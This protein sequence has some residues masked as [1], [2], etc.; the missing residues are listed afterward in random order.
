MPDSSSPR[1]VPFSQKEQTGEWDHG[2]MP[3]SLEREHSSLLDASTTVNPFGPPFSIQEVVSR[4]IGEFDRYP[5]PWGKE[6]LSSLAEFLSVS[7]ENVV[8]GPGSTALIYRWMDAVRPRRL[9]LFEPVFSEYRKAAF[10]Y[11]IPCETI[12]A[13]IPLRFKG[14]L[15]PG[16]CR[17][18]GI[19]LSDPFPL[20]VGDYLILVN[21]V[22]PTGQELLRE[23]LLAFW[24]RVSDTGA[25]LLLDE[26]FQDFLGNRSSLLSE[27]GDRN[28]RLSILRSLTKATGLPGIR[29]GW[30]AGT[31]SL[32]SSV[33]LRLGPW[34][35][36]TLEDAVVCQWSRSGLNTGALFQRVKDARE[37]LSERLV[38][39][40]FIVAEGDSPFLFVYTGWGLEAQRRK[41]AVFQRSGVYIR[42]AEGFGPLSG[43]DYI[44]LGF[45]AFRDPQK[46]VTLLTELS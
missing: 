40:G 9:I 32:V 39:R 8:V 13:S 14:G 34:A 44:R 37:E 19:H 15:P 38:R 1:D 17:N 18:W 42:V 33:R 35:V 28:E 7:T 27:I 45:G 16:S 41:E 29:T 24:K 36:G 2:G 12:P 4:A 43:M 6:T 22:N 25:G 3:F 31:S 20:Q 23:D 5:D 26:S 21:P 30:L 10:L 11:G 46:I